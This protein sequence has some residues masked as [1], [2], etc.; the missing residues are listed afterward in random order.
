MPSQFFDDRKRPLCTRPL[1][2]CALAAALGI[3][4]CKGASLDDPAPGAALQGPAAEGPLASVSGLRRLSVNEYDNT[5]A[6]LLKDP[7]RSG[8]KLLPQDGRSPFDNEYALQVASLA[9]VEGVERLAG[10]AAQRLLRDT[11]RRDEIVGCKPSASDDAM[12]FRGFL[13]RFGQLAFRRTLAPEELDAMT[14]KLM[15]LAVES[16]D[17]YA[18]VDGAVRTFLQSPWFLY[19]VELGQSASGGAYKLAGTEVASRL[20]Y[21]LW[22]SMPD[23]ALLAEAEGG[24][25]EDRALRRAVAA[26]MLDDGRARARVGRFHALWLGYE[27]LKLPPALSEDMQTETQAL[28]DRVVFEDKRSWLVILRA[29]E[30]FVADAL[31][32]HY[33]LPPT[34]VSGP[35]WVKYGAAPRQGLFSH[36]TFLSNGAKFSDTSPTMRGLAV[37]TRVFCESIPPPPPGVNPDEPPAAPTGTA[38]TCKVDRY[39]A[40][41]SGG[42]AGCHSQLDPIGFGLERFDQQGRYR[43]Y[44]ANRPE[45]AI[46]G[47]GELVGVGTFEGPKGLADV[48][49]AS[50]RLN[51]C[52]VKQFYKFA[53]GR[54]ELDE[55]DTQLVAQLTER[56]GKGEFRFDE[57]LLEHVASESFGYRR[58]ESKGGG[59]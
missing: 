58:E 19:R 25:L 38:G 33:G 55:A 39:S 50:Q 28:L 8:V 42:C 30:T 9:L 22:G 53:I 32:R 29:D 2:S 51:A 54:S 37:R 12:C 59:Q 44:D 6:D 35:V 21:L 24:K 52:V 47:K 40:H 15:P 49:I 23:R 41:A 17:F 26:K 7:S 27:T 56:V 18:A 4:A 57:V 45:C 10:D 1:A 11:A 36:G 34:G 14:M 16:N 5:I 31:A 20:S 43:T 13:E 48:A 3:A 46:E